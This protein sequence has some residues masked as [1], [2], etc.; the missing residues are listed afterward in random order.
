MRV[1][2]L[3][4]AAGGGFPQWNCWCPTCRVAR[5]TPA[6]AHPRSQ[7]SIAVSADGDRWFLCNASP[8]VR[9][10]LDRLTARRSAPP[11]DVVRAVPI[12]GVMFTDAEL[13]HTLGLAL[14]REARR[15][16]VYATEP[17]EAV[18]EHDSRI[19]PTTRAFAD[20]TVTRLPLG[21]PIP[22]ADRDGRPTPLSV[23]A[24][25]V[26]G[27]P[28]RFATRDQVGHTV[29]LLI[30]DSHTGGTVAFVPG[31]GD[32]TADVRSYLT[33]AG[34]IL[35]DGTFW[36]G[37]E[38]QRLAISPSTAQQMGH[39]PISGPDGSLDALARFPLARRVYT[40]INNSNPIL[41]EDSL[42][43]RTVVDAGVIVGA[44]GAEF[45]I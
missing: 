39:Q 45:M 7:S 37:D 38:L 17:V 33:R 30:H 16:T 9:P 18:L 13:D 3:G 23:E 12:E 40:H 15:L 35:F 41:I 1:L 4:T 25:A 44:D 5:D 22:L 31:C 6:R 8:D 34:L 10:Q 29:G 26:P 24:F 2:L 28:P 42:E 32:I 20:I 11:A 27:D 43:R 14:L 21:R 19:L 36:T